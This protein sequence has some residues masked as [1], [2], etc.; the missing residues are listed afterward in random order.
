MH[1]WNAQEE[2]TYFVFVEDPPPPVHE[3]CS[4][5]LYPPQR[6]CK[7]GN[8]RAPWW[9]SERWRWRYHHSGWWCWPCCSEGKG[10]SYSWSHESQH[11]TSNQ[12]RVSKDGNT[13]SEKLN[14]RKYIY[15]SLVIQFFSQYFNY[16][17]PLRKYLP[18]SDSSASSSWIWFSSRFPWIKYNEESTIL[19]N[20]GSNQPT[21]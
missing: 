5:L 3:D 16:F 14:S 17:R 7:M 19:K 21:K 10:R 8:W 9:W 13:Y 1:F 11:A 18:H 15:I 2:V 12:I 4:M 20:E 6:E